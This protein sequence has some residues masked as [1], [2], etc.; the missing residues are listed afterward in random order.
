[1]PALGWLGTNLGSMAGGGIAIALVYRSAGAPAWFVN[2]AFATA[3]VHAVIAAIIWARRKTID[4][5]HA[6]TISLLS[7][8]ALGLCL[9]IFN[10]PMGQRSEAIFTVLI[11]AMTIMHV[12]MMGAVVGI[13]VG[14]RRT[15]HS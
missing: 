9:W 1:M 2:L 6:F 12:L 7:G 14:E 3:A 15:S 13:N 4:G 10:P 11:P 5:G 8:A